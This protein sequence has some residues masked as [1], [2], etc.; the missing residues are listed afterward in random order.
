MCLLQ[1]NVYLA[2]LPIFKLVGCFVVVELYEFLYTLDINPI[3]VVSGL[4]KAQASEVVLLPSL[5]SQQSPHY[6][7]SL[8]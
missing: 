5:L 4:L 7:L 1:K 2:S 6:S 8:P 3:L